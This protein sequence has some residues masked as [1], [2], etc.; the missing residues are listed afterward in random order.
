VNL[1]III[2]VYTFFP[3]VANLQAAKCVDADPLQDCLDKNNQTEA[4][5][6]LGNGLACLFSLGGL[7]LL[8]LG[9]YN[10]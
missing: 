9:F 2:I 6:I 7:E 10:S 8:L 4:G 1:T 3:S 5:R